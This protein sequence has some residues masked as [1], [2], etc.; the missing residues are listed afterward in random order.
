MPAQDTWGH[1]G[2][3][4]PND[5]NYLTADLNIKGHITQVGQ[6][7]G[8]PGRLGILHQS[9]RHESTGPPWGPPSPS[10]AKDT[11]C[12]AKWQETAITRS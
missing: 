10:G 6:S 9:G 12:V 5:L 8:L 7:S 3:K 4:T 1:K 2:Q 11:V